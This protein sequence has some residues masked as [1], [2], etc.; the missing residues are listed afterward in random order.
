MASHEFTTPKTD[1]TVGTSTT[2]YNGDRFTYVD[3]NRIKNNVLY[4]YELATE[5]YPINN[6]IATYVAN[7]EAY[8]QGGGN[9]NIYH[10]FYLYDG[11]TDRALEDFV[12]ADEIN[13]FEERIHFLNATMGEIVPQPEK[14][15]YYYDNGVFINA[16]ELNR[17]E[18]ITLALQPTLYHMFIN[19]RRLAF[20]L[21]QKTNHIDL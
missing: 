1:W 17:L 15:N 5:I 7:S 14:P 12:Y 18:N 6:E 9:E 11:E 19:R 13:Y 2:T 8:A 3:F 20:T 10:F 21:S 16:T 4:L